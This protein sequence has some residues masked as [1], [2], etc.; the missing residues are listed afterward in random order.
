M[1]GSKPEVGAADNIDAI[2]RLEKREKEKLALHHRIFHMI[3]GFVGTTH[4][5]LLQCLTVGCWIAFNLSITKP[6]DEFPFPALATVLSL[7][8][9][10]LTS[11]VLIRQSLVDQTLE[12]RDHLELQ[13]NLL[14][15]REATRSLRILQ[16]IAEKLGI[17]D[18]EDCKEDELAEET[19]VD[20]IAQDLKAREDREKDKM[21]SDV[22]AGATG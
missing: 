5:I 17:G 12:R 11:C 15:E 20:Q 10:L 16:K 6:L 1:Q 21:G 22:K 18:I 8:A 13:I 14:A 19:S 9:V 7:E 4:F 2:L 3:G